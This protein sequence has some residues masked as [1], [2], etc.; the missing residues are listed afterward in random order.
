MPEQ[1]RPPIK[2]CPVCG[3]TMLARKSDE[4]LPH[5]DV[6]NCPNCWMVVSYSRRREP[7]RKSEI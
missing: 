4:S 3:I 7:D 6:F 1:P 5:F 2:N